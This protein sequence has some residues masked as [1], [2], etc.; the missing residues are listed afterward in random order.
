[1]IITRLKGGLGNQMFQYAAGY[2]LSRE[3]N[4]KLLVDGSFLYESANDNTIT[5]RQFELNSFGIEDDNLK[6]G[7]VNRIR[8]IIKSRLYQAVQSRSRFLPWKYFHEKQFSYDPDFFKLTGNVYLEGYWQSEKYFIKYREELRA[9]FQ[10]I[11][12]LSE[13]SEALINYLRKN[14]TVS[15]HIRRGDLISNPG[16]AAYHG[17]CDDE[18]YLNALQQLRSRHPFIKVIVFSDEPEYVREKMQFL[19]PEVIVDW[20]GNRGSEDLQ[21]MKHCSHHIIAN[22]SFSW[23]G[24]WLNPSGDKEVFAPRR[25][26]LNDT[27]TGSLIPAEWKRI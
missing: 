3:N 9:K 16:A 1:M 18:Y 6:Y 7:R 21:L 13:K 14:F 4:S 5:P 23:W 26:F 8:K 15:V 22:S 2:S 24:A 11:L 12:P 19:E 10:S 25:W 20:N 17:I 27:Y